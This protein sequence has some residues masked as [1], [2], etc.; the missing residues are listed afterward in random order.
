[1]GIRFVCLFTVILLTGCLFE[2]GGGNGNGRHRNI[3]AAL[4]ASCPENPLIHGIPK[5]NGESIDSLADVGVTYRLQACPQSDSLSLG[6]DIFDNAGYRVNAIRFGIS[7]AECRT[8]PKDSLTRPGLK[9]L[10]DNRNEDESPVPS[11]YYFL[12]LSSQ[13]VPL[14]GPTSKCIFVLRENDLPKP[15]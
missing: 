5:T 2:G 13:T 14:A 1:M 15:R 6:M 10:W 11:G 8:L 4:R 7:A 12:Y 3:S 9:V